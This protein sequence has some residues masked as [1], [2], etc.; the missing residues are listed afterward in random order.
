M[1]DRV[2]EIQERQLLIQLDQAVEEYGGSRIPLYNVHLG[3]FK[4]QDNVG[5][6]RVLLTM[7]FANLFSILIMGNDMFCYTI[8]RNHMWREIHKS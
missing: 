4:V 6:E 7:F 8:A 5:S 3:K 1:F 2:R